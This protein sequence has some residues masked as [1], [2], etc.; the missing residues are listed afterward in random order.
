M[1]KSY[2]IFTNLFIALFF[3]LIACSGKKIPYNSNYPSN[4]NST[5]NKDQTSSQVSYNGNGQSYYNS[6]SYSSQTSIPINSRSA[7]KPETYV[8]PVAVPIIKPPLKQQFIKQQLKPLIVLDPGHGG[9]DFGAYSLE[10]PKYQEKFLT[11]TTSKM[12][13]NYLEQM[14]YTVYM[15]RTKDIFIE[16][17]KRSEMA[18]SK[19][20]KLFVSIHYNTAPAKNAEGIEIFYY[21]A[22]ENKK[23]SKESKDLA[24]TILSNLLKETNAKSRGVKH[25]NLAVIRQTDMPA[26]LI[27]GGFL[28]NANELQKIKDAP[29]LKKISWGI[30]VGIDEYVSKT[31]ASPKLAIASKK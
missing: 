16:L 13:A 23:R 24:E 28:T 9:K 20:P 7:I 21:N 6:Q 19:K 25:G 31:V 18:N 1:K 17:D 2:Q 14:G 29:Y 11:L 8:P 3:V 15:T 30:A 12:I 27:E 4:S 26:V 22:G 10:S 5:N